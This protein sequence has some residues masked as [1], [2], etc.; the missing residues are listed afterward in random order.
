M[1]DGM[2]VVVMEGWA[3]SHSHGPQPCCKEE[4]ALQHPEISLTIKAGLI[5]THYLHATVSIGHIV[6]LDYLILNMQQHMTQIK[7]VDQYN[8][9]ALRCHGNTTNHNTVTNCYA[10]LGTSGLRLCI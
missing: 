3:G 7:W 2:E 9:R 8:I 4:L 5:P 6:H 10:Y 1:E